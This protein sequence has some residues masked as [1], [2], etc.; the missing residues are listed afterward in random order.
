MNNPKNIIGDIDKMPIILQKLSK[1]NIVESSI[2]K[3]KRVAIS[4][5]QTTNFKTYPLYKPIS[6]IIV[7]LK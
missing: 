3:E 1:I 7:S 6:K 5:Y 4:F 2:E